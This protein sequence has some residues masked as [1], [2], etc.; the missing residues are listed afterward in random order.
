MRTFY[1]SAMGYGKHLRRPTGAME[2]TGS[3]I[4]MMP[5][6]ISVPVNYHAGNETSISAH[7]P[8][9]PADGHPPVPP[10]ALFPQRFQSREPRLGQGNRMFPL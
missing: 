6:N 5:V 9:K 3:V 1:A 7:F 8:R 4:S 2:E 10:K